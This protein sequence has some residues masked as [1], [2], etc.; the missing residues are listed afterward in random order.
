ML[1]WQVRSTFGAGCAGIFVFAWTDSWYRGGNEILDWDFGLVTR[2]REPKPALDAVGRAFARVPFDPD[3]EWPAVSV[4]VCSYNGAET[5]RDTLEGIGRLAYPNVEAVVVDDGSTDDTAVI[6][7]GYDVRLIRTEN[8]GLSSARNTG[9]HAATGEIVAYIDDDA[10]PD[11]HWLHYLVHSYRDG[12]FVGMGGPNLLPPEDGP[13]AECVANAPGGPAHVLLTDREAEH[14]PGCNMSFRREALLAVGG[15]DPRYRAA[16]DDVDVC[17]RVREEVGPVGFSPAAVVW[18]HRRSSLRRYWAQQRGYGKAEALLAEKWPE[19]YNSLGHLEWSGRIYGRGLTR[20][21]RLAPAQVYQGVWG[22]APFQSLYRESPATLASVALMPEWYVL[23][24]LLAVLSA[25]GA[26]WSPLLLALPLLLGAVALPVAQA[27]KSAADARFESL[28]RTATRRRALALRGLT[29]L[30]HLAQPAA[31]LDGRLR[32]NLAP[33]RRY[34]RARAVP[35]GREVSVWREDWRSPEAWLEAVEG[36]LGDEGVPVLRG[37]VF[38]RW[39]LEVRGGAFGTVRLLMAIEEH[40]SG[41][42]LARF[43]LT[44]KVGPWT[45][46]ALASSSVLT[47]WALLDGAWAAG[48]GLLALALLLAGS[49]Y[50]SCAAATGAALDAVGALDTTDVLDRERPR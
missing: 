33:W 39:D 21:L 23:V 49:A 4:V 37:G 1:T 6:A 41:K 3:A 19:R 42:Q 2:D 46:V 40:G 44:P 48:A 34:G 17:W 10:Y 14:V 7:S 24:G 45:A 26:A 13:V 16:G 27:V 15:F 28:P 22:S 31:R 30:L 11:P 32:H 25:L 47:L 5:L 20:A 35:T 50:R 36:L 43:R 29:A 12:D 8:R 38:D 18:H 9:L